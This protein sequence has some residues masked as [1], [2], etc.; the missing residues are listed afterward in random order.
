MARS[1]FLS[2][3]K[4]I[5]TVISS[6]RHKRHLLP[7]SPSSHLVSLCAQS[8]QTDLSDLSTSSDSTIDPLH[9]TSLAMQCIVLISCLLTHLLKFFRIL[10]CYILY[11]LM[12]RMG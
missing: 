8:N 6:P 1:L 9:S 10:M 2:L 4:S 12:F 7:L 11:F 3:N 5:S